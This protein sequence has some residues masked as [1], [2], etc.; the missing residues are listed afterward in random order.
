VIV[1]WENSRQ[2]RKIESEE[3]L[4]P[5]FS[6]LSGVARQKL[7]AGSRVKCVSAGKTLPHL[8]LNYGF[9]RRK[10]VSR[11][12]GRICGLS[13]TQKA[14]PDAIDQESKLKIVTKSCGVIDNG[15]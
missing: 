11:H 15:Y 10:G 4:P 8:L 3:S 13:V 1:G 12:K 6:K 14:C 9:P 2:T 7:D 5:S